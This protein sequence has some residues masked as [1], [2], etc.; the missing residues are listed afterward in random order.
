MSSGKPSDVRVTGAAL[1]LLPVKTRVP[2]KF[3]PEVLTE[4]T[5][6]R[7]RLTVEGRDGRVAHGWGECPLNVQW[8]WPSSL[9]Y[10]VRHDRMVDFCFDLAKAWESYDAAGH[11]L[12]IGSDF[13]T[14][15]LPGLIESANSDP[16]N[17]EAM[18]YLAALVCSSA[19]DVALHDAYGVLHERDIY[20]LYGSE[21]LTRDLS[22]F[23]EPATDAHPVSFKGR[24]PSEFLVA[25]GRAVNSSLPAWHLV[26][27]LDPLTDDDRCGDEPD[28]GYPVTL[29]DW[30]ER[31]G[32]RCLKIKLRGNDQT[33]DYARI[34]RVGQLAVA[35]ACQWL[36]ADFNCTVTEPGYVNEILD[37][38]RDEH[39]RLYGMLLY[40]EQPVPYELERDRIDARSIAARKPVF[41]DESAHDWQHVRLGRELGWSGVALKTCKTQK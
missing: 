22:A 32:L 41:L 26:G 36:T 10:A 31:D 15:Q 35:H 11:P 34:V 19:F 21:Y 39:P 30:I 24:W 6:A 1:Y 28:D 3:G 4:V 9:T 7:V 29:S 25:N 16:A 20:D 8:A 40:I 23:L 14:Q 12:E 17:Q 5:C 13:L 2:L 18:P 33:W 37:Q 38:L 27:G